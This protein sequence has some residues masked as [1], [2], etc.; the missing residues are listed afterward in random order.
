MHLLATSNKQSNVS[1][2]S[3]PLCPYHI[4]KLH[5]LGPILYRHTRKIFI[6]SHPQKA[7]SYHQAQVVKRKGIQITNH[8]PADLMG[9]S[10]AD[11]I[12]EAIRNQ[13]G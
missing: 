5:L 3:E 13:I 9:A 7:A 11:M 2:H 1:E 8:H 6:Y 10:T 12:G 4:P